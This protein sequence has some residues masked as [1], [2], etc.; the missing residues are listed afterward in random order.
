M[1]LFY[2]WSSVGYN[3]FQECL[4]NFVV[5]QIFCPP[6]SGAWWGPSPQYSRLRLYCCNL[7][8][9]YWC[10]TW[11]HEPFPQKELVIIMDNASI[12]KS[13]QL[14][15]MIKERYVIISMFCLH[16]SEWFFEEEWGLDSTVL[17]L[18]KKWTIRWS[19][20]WPLSISHWCCIQ[21]NHPWKTLWMVHRLWLQT[22]IPLQLQVY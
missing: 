14:Q 2:P 13:P 1:R 9:I 19:Y 22:M 15:S 21:F 7:Q 4:S 8:P 12:H 6:C 18:C 5:L 10:F 17:W 20:I 3:F 11:Q 16:L